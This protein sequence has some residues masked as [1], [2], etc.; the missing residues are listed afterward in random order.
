MPRWVD[1]LGRP[2]LFSGER[3]RVIRGGEVT[4]RD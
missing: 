2:P 3:E 1:I 4:G